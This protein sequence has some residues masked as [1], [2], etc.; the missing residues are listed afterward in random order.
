MNPVIVK[1][2]SR[3]LIVPCMIDYS[4]ILPNLNKNVG[5]GNAS[6]DS[7]QLVVDVYPFTLF[8]I[9]GAFSYIVYW[10]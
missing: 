5:S 9:E 1:T 3:H 7:V 4:T 2:S 10:Y 6:E 8:Q